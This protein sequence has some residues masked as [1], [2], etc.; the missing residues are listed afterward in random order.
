MGCVVRD[1]MVVVVYC[2][3]AYGRRKPMAVVS[4]HNGGL[5]HR[6]GWHSPS[7]EPRTRLV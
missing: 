7:G 6:R 3:M 1:M 4:Y 2:G 5:T